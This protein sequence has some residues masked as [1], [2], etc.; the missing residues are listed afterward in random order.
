ME[1]AMKYKNLNIWFHRKKN[2]IW[3]SFKEDYFFVDFLE[4]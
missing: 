4:K 3:L 2:I 1:L